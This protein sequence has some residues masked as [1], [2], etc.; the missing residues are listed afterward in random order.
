[1][2]ERDIEL[3]NYRLHII[4]YKKKEVLIN[5]NYVRQHEGNYLL[6]ELIREIGG[7][8]TNYCKNNKEPSLVVYKDKKTK[9][10]NH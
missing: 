1:M 9:M 5:L 7:K 3:N 8:I 6:F 2:N 10:K 4:R